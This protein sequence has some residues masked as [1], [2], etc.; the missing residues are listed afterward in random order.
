MREKIGKLDCVRRPGEDP[1]RC[2]VLLHGFGADASDLLPLAD[3]LDPEG[4]WDFV[5]PE[6]PLE[7][8]IGPMM[9]GR[10]WFPLSVRELQGDFDFTALRPPHI[11]ASADL[12]FDMMF[13]LNAK[14]CILG[15]FSQGA[16]IATEVALN[17]PEDVAGLILLSGTLLDESGWT[18]KA[19]VLQGKPVLQ[20][21]GM[22]DP[23]LPFAF[24]QRLMNLLKT[25]GAD[26]TFV[27]FT[28]GHEIPMSVLQKTKEFLLKSFG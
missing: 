15:G 22:Q 26:L 12:V 24:A 16:M 19:G 28:G 10:G 8:P 13:H 9:S 21:H 11:D 3:F 6:A 23:V 27:P 4:E 2:V 14:T 20:S 17:N 1:S 25:A 5:F 7:V 18:K